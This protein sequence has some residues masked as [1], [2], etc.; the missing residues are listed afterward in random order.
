MN[1]IEPIRR[2]M[3]AQPFRAFTLRMVDGTSY[4]V[5][6]P[7]FIAFPPIRRPRE[8][9]FFTSADGEEYETHAIDIGLIQV[10][11]TPGETAR[12]EAEPRSDDD[13]S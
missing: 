3:H 8:I 9:W 6:H 7:D 2:A 10:V 12:V 1:N 5:Q 13:G 11:V 4:V